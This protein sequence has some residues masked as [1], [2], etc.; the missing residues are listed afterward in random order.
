MLKLEALTPASTDRWSSNAEVQRP[1]GDIQQ[2]C[3]SRRGI[4][5]LVDLPS[6]LFMAVGRRALPAHVPCAADRMNCHLWWRATLT[7]GGNSRR[8]DRMASAWEFVRVD[9]GAIGAGS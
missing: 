2:G 8:L 4:K 7:R 9:Q 1:F 3:H 5:S 6:I